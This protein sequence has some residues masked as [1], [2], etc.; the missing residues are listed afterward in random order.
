MREESVLKRCEFLKLLGGGKV[1]FVR[2]N[3]GNEAR[4]I[5]AGGALKI[6]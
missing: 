3:S 2:R 5:E 4:G 6:P 1:L